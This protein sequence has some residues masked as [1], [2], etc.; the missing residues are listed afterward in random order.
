MRDPGAVKMDEVMADLLETGSNVAHYRIVSRLGE[1]GMGAV[2][3][4]DDTRLGRRVALKVLPVNVAADPERMHR[5]VLEAK[6]ASALTHPNIAYIYE[7][8]QQDGVWFLAMEYVE[9]QPL[10]ARILDGPLAIR[11]A[12]AIGIQVADALDA[13]HSKGIVHRDIKPANLMVTPRG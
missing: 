3:L 5:F 12:L 10:S 13:A 7:I 11:E 2:Y 1:G 9:G 6:L 8:G 4:A